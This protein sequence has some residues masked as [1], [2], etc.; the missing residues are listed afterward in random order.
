MSK[1]KKAI[2]KKFRDDCF[3]RDNYRCKTCYAHVPKDMK[4]EDFLDAHH[5]IPRNILNG[6]YFKHNGISLCPGCHIKAELYY[7][8]GSAAPGFHPE[9]LFKL[10]NSSAEKAI[11]A[12]KKLQ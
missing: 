10:I 9:D 1:V 8:T 4:P 2:R 11:E 6:G 3:K 5:I 7:S 12:S